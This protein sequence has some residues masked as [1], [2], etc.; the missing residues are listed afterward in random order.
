M[1]VPVTRLT[2]AAACMAMLAAAALAPTAQSE[3]FVPL[4]TG[5]LEGW[6]VVPDG[7]PNFTVADGLLRV[8][9]PSG[10]LKSERRYGD[11]LLRTEFRFVTSNADSGI[12][13]RAIGDTPFMRNWPNNSYQVQIRNPSTP[14]PFPPVGGLFRHGT[15]QGDTDMDEEAVTRAF[16]GTG[17]WQTLEVDVRGEQLVVRLNGTQVLTAANIGNSPG[18]IGV[19]G[20]VGVVEYRAIEIAER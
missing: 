18:H 3:D 11:F 20:E 19:Q 8:D 10:W 1:G 17:E 12:F 7:A 6:E 4:F 2:T 15:P 13:I 16:T 5:T 9:G 14:S